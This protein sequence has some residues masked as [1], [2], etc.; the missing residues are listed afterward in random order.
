M[1]TLHRI[2]AGLDVHK[3][4]VVAC[5]RRIDDRGRGHQEVKTFGTTTADLLELL[6]WLQQQQ[7][8]IVAMEST[9]VYWKPV[10]NLLEGPVEVLLVN[11]EHIKK[12]PG[13][14]TDV[15]DCEWIAQ[16]LQHG[17]LRASFVPPRPIREL[18]DLTRQ[19]TQLVGEKASV[20]NRIQKVLE[21]ANIKLGSVASDVLG[22]SGRDMLRS[23]I[24]G[25]DSAEA[26]ANLARG[27]LRDKLPQLRKALQGRVT[28]HHRFLL[29]LHLDHLTHLEALIGQLDNRIHDEM[30]KDRPPPAE[31]PPRGT[32]AAAPPAQAPATAVEVAAPSAPPPSGSGGLGLWQSLWLLV[33]IPGINRRTAEVVLAEIGADMSRF[34]TAQQLASWAGLCP[35]NNESAGKR[36]SGRTTR[37]SRWLR[38]A[39]VQAAWA[40]SHTKATYLSARYRRL[41]RR[42]GKKKA[43]VA[44]A[45]TLLVMCY[46]VLRKGEAYRELGADYLDKMEPDR[47][48]KQLVRQLEKLG[49]K[50][51]LESGEAA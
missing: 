27:R 35:G 19:R 29:R 6:D 3:D 50:V 30:E 11:P 43:L 17:L 28:E 5:V 37:G 42:R 51:T 15:K 20:S 13:R 33:T 44:V 46:E 12:V 40:A 26:L 16:L 21:D 41:A 47:R 48:T 1:D 22:A 31:P 32:S 45:H 4:T 9:G 38:S 49:H 2:C 36:R 7:V 23:L 39:L 10:F 18:R 25:V 14:K 8:P 34:A 24:A